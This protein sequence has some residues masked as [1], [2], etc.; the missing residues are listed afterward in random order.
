M[1]LVLGEF[2][3]IDWDNVPKTEHPGEQGVATW[4][5][6]QRGDVRIRMV[7]Y[8]RGYLADHWCQKGHII[9]VVEGELLTQLKD[10]R[11]IKL[12]KGMC[13]TVSDE[14]EAHRSSTK[15]GATLFIVD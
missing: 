12:T 1:K 11:E 15:A 3:T 2:E 14:G 7:N 13:Y 8:S 5:T 6:V 9:L 10:G 4:Q